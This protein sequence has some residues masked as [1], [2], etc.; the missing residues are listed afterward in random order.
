MS[1]RNIKPWFA[2]LCPAIILAVPGQALAQS[3]DA[4]PNQDPEALPDGR[5]PKAPFSIE[6]SVAIVTDYRFRGVSL[7]NNDP[8]LQA[9][10]E[11]STQTGLYA[12]AWSSTIA[13]YSGAHAELDG[14]AGYRHSIAVVQL[15]V[16]AIGYFYPSGN[17]VNGFELYGSA[18]RKVGVA[19]VKGGGSYTPRQSNFG[20]DDGAYLFG[21]VTAGIP[22]T[23]FEMRAHIGREAGVN[24][25]PNGSKV[26]WLVGI[27]A[28]FGRVTASLAWLDTDV[29]S[30]IGGSAYRSALVASLAIGL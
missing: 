27:D 26:D 13:N 2:I 30:D 21:E 6:A 14:Y 23:P 22:R 7:S 12:G 24:A 20:D 19:T 29:A 17:D 8:A 9:G 18:S 10:V 11:L 5:R 25:G 3:V 1:T 4:R 16:G 28:V 15:D